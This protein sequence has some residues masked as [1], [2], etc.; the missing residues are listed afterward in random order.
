MLLR[1]WFNGDGF[2]VEHLLPYTQALS[3]STLLQTSRLGVF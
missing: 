3:N 1:L 2:S